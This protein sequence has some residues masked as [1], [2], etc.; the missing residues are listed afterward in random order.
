MRKI[1]RTSPPDCLNNAIPATKVAKIGYYESVEKKIETINAK[2]RAGEKPPKFN[3]TTRWNTLQ[4]TR[5]GISAIRKNLLEM[6]D[7]CCA[8]CGVKITK[9]SDLEVEHF[10]PKGRTAFPFLAYCWENYLPSCHTCNTAKCTFVPA[11][12]KGKQIVDSVLKGKP[13]HSGATFYEWR[14]ILEDTEDRLLEPS[15]DNP[16]EHLEFMPEFFMYNPKT[17]IGKETISRFFSHKEVTDNWEKLSL[18]IRIIVRDNTSPE[19][20]IEALIDFGGYAFLHHTFL[21]Y[22]KREKAEGRL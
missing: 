13:A 1:Q 2:I 9:N 16:A 14:S 10:L 8:Y 7:L 3:I 11:S 20:V 22:W 12:L 19:D 18:A 21:D 15:F 4:K 17:E 5:E 6:S